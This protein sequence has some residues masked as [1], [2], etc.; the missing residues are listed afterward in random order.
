MLFQNLYYSFF[1]LGIWFAWW[2]A[3]RKKIKNPE[4]LEKLKKWNPSPPVVSQH[5]LSWQEEMAVEREMEERRI[6]VGGG[7][8][9]NVQYGKEDTS[10]GGDNVERRTQ[11]GGG[12]N[13][14]RRTQVGGGASHYPNMYW[15]EWKRQRKI[16]GS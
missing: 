2:N 16:T 4:N 13:V 6:Q 7:A 12:D 3:V 14:E 10:G 1:F 15:L 11:V 8:R 9:N 5:L